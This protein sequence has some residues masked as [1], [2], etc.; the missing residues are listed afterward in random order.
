MAKT[1]QEIIADIA[2]HFSGQ[3]Y[4]QCYVG[5]TS[6]IDKRLFGDH[7]VSKK[8]DTWIYRIATNNQIARDVEQYFLDKGMDGAGGGGDLTATTV[9]AYRKSSITDP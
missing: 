7:K 1:K 5:I 9:Y 3:N 6:D 2:D 8:S 4:R